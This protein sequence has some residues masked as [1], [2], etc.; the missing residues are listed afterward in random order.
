MRKHGHDHKVS[1]DRTCVQE[2]IEHKGRR[3]KQDIV[4]YM[5]KNETNMEP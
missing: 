5:M 3:E 1:H 2:H 4:K